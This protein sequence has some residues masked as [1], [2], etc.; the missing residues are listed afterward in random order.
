MLL[1]EAEVHVWY[2]KLWCAKCHTGAKPQ[3][4]SRYDTEHTLIYRIIPTLSLNDRF[5]IFKGELYP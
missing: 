4:E 2:G 3:G 5:I 1:G